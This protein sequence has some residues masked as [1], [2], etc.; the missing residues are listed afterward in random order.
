MPFSGLSVFNPHRDVSRER[1]HPICYMEHICNMLFI[2]IVSL[3]QSE[4]KIS[5]P[6]YTL[7]KIESTIQFTNIGSNS[8]PKEIESHLPRVDTRK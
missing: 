8:V 1:D 3:I 5:N 4:Q 7:D 2:A 6:L